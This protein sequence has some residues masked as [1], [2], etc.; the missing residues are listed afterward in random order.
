MRTKDAITSAARVFWHPLPG[1]W[2]SLDAVD[3]HP[4]GSEA[5]EGKP[6]V[7]RV[8]AHRFGCEALTVQGRPSRL[9]QQVL[10]GLAG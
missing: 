6:T 8:S 10:V 4:G 9:C 3:E 2:S 5:F 1:L 7:V